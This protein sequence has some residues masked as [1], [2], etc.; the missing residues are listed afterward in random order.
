VADTDV[1]LDPDLAAL[2]DAAAAAGTAPMVE[3]SVEQVRE[4]LRE[5][6]VLCADGPDVE[7][8]DL[9]PGE[10]RPVAVRVY[11]HPDAGTT[12]VYAH[13]GGWVT[14]DLEYADELCRFLARDAGV[15]VVS[16]DYRLAPEHPFPA[17]LEDLTGTW[18]WARAA[19][20]G[21]LA[22]GG[23]SAGGNLAAALAHR[24]VGSEAPAPSFLLLVYPVL[25][26]PDAK[27]SYRSRASAF[28]IGA[29]EMRWFFDHYLADGLP[30]EPTPDVV[31]LHA[32]LSRMPRTHLVVAGHDPLRDEGVAFAEGL[33]R[34]GVAVNLREHAD[35][36]HGFLRLTAVSEAAR[37]AR[38]GIVDAVRGLLPEGPVPPPQSMPMIEQSLRSSYGRSTIPEADS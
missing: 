32:D 11:A 17:G 2:R 34:A 25:G 26:L 15:R 1:P 14:G 16:T 29:A 33:S 23:D 35:L 28:P 5:G 3:L 7:V 18:D 21:P 6:H 36:C 12:L 10:G 19:Y 4:R 13:G 20:G 9:G 22:L 38:S 30:Q 37:G 27:P 31:P 8:L 24:L